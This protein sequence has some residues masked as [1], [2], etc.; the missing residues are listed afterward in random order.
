[1]KL[2]SDSR[3]SARKMTEIKLEDKTGLEAE[4][5]YVLSV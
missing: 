1:M 4:P 3:G 2:Y 5:E